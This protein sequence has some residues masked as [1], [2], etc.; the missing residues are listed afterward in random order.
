[1]LD[2]TG[3]WDES[4]LKA[5][6]EMIKEQDTRELGKIRAIA[7][8]H[9]MKEVLNKSFKGERSFLRREDIQAEIEN[10]R[11]HLLSATTQHEASKFDRNQ[12]GF[13]LL[14]ENGLRC[15]VKYRGKD[16]H[17][18]NTRRHSKKNKGAASATGHTAYSLDEAD[19]FIFVV[20]RSP[21]ARVTNNLSDSKIVAIP[22]TSLED[23][24]NPGFLRPRISKRVFEQWASKDVISVIRELDNKKKHQTKEKTL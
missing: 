10:G 20:P 4:V 14:S 7:S 21:N 3:T 16:L 23:T 19:V 1:M 24:K 9:I 5:H 12:S 15:Q 22:S 13:D 6:E 18:E 8:E 2:L 11:K 17:L